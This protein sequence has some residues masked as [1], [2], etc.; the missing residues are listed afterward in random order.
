MLFLICCASALSVTAESVKGVE[1]TGAGCFEQLSGVDGWGRWTNLAAYRGFFPSVVVHDRLSGSPGF[2]SFVLDEFRKAIGPH[3][4]APRGQLACGQLTVFGP[5]VLT[6]EDLELLEVSTERAGIRDLL[7]EYSHWSPDRML[8]FSAYLAE[9]S[10]SGRVLANRALAAT[11]MDVLTR[12]MQRLFEKS[13][14]NGDGDG[15]AAAP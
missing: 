1:T 4:P 12:S 3:V 13:P 6:A 8:P 5:I 15:P 11:S 14:R 7:A 2:G 10:A 9:I